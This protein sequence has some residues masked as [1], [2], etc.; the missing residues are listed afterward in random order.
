[1]IDDSIQISL[2]VN[3]VDGGIV[4]EVTPSVRN[5]GNAK[6]VEQLLKFFFVFNPGDAPVI[7]QSI[8]TFA[9]LFQIACAITGIKTDADHVYPVTR[10]PFRK[11]AAYLLEGF[12]ER[13]TERDTTGIDKLNQKI[14]L[15][16]ILQ[17]KSLSPL[18]P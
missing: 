8:E 13:G 15:P 14:A 2:P 5:D 17:A 4:L 10:S 7:R 1:M 16:V 6:S 11:L 18:I 9:I 3:E 12:A